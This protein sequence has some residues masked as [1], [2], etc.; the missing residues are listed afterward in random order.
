MI[1]LA[2]TATSAIRALTV[3]HDRLDH[4]I[5]GIAAGDRAAFRRLYAFM[6]MRVWHTAT[7]APLCPADAVAV[8][9]STFV[10]V[11]HSAGAA[12]R[13]DARDW[14]ATVT[15]GCVN[16]RLRLID[17]NGRRGAHP[18]EPAVATDR[19][20]QTPTVADYDA[21]IHRALTALLGAG[22]A[23]IRTRPGVFARIDDLDHA[24]ATIAAATRAPQQASDRQPRYHPSVPQRTRR[25]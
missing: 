24:L 17:A 12:A 5:S 19:Q 9:R 25:R 21:H 22:G 1:E 16:D 14:M 7:E 11:W 20:H 13:Y 10:E 23:V 8:T 2:A 15:A 6:A 4:L 18:A 3:E